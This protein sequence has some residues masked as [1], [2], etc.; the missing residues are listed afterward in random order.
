[1]PKDYRD[2]VMQCELCQS[3]QQ[4][5][6]LLAGDVQTLPFPSEIFSSYAIDCMGPL[7]KLKGQDSVLVVV[8]RAVGFSWLIP[9][10][11]RGGHHEN[12]VAWSKVV[13]NAPGLPRGVVVPVVHLVH[14]DPL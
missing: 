9:T 2:F 8:D 13:L 11:V 3:N 7:T 4:R 14:S 6:T 10:S 12:V 5:N 1:M